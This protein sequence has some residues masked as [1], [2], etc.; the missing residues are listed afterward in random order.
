MS[1]ERREWALSDLL[2]KSSTKN[3][4]GRHAALALL[5][6]TGLGLQ[7]ANSQD[8]LPLQ[9]L[10]P[11]KPASKTWRIAGD[12][13][14]DLAAANVLKTSGGSG[15]LVNMPTDKEH[16]QDLFTNLVHGDAD[17]EFST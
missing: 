4:A 2:H 8:A 1:K 17:V 13:Q 15:V 10:S 14:A 7:Q 11:F 5:L 12:V 16:G 3:A 6:S 9:D